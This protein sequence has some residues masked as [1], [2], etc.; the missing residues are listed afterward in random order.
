M[1]PDPIYPD[2]VGR[3]ARSPRAKGTGPWPRRQVPDKRVRRGPLQRAELKKSGVYLR[4]D[5][6][7]QFAYDSAG[8]I[9]TLTVGKDVFTF[10]YLSNGDLDRINDFGLNQDMVFTYNLDGTVDEITVVTV[11]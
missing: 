11:F 9:D 10:T 3:G 7:A 5:E 8:K 4:S 6:I 1:S 2:E